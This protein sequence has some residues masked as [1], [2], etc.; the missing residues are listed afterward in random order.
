MFSLLPPYSAE[1]YK[2]SIDTDSTYSL[3]VVYCT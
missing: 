1:V 2:L 3:E